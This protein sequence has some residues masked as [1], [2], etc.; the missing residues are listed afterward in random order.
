[1]N[2]NVRIIRGDGQAFTLRQFV[3]MW[4]ATTT[5]LLKSSRSA[6]AA[7]AVVTLSLIALPALT[8][9]AST[10]HNGFNIGSGLCTTT[11]TVK[12]NVVLQSRHH[13]VT[14]TTWNWNWWWTTTTNPVTSTTW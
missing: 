11:K 8:S 2:K 13:G 5:R 3:G 9:S 7:M 12:S 1:M 6:M 4:R 14:T 10:N